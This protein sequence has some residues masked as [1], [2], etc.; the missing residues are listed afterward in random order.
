MLFSLWWSKLF[1]PAVL[2][3]LIKRPL[4]IPNARHERLDDGALFEHDE[5]RLN[6]N[7]ILLKPPRG[8]RSLL[9]KI[10]FHATVSP[11]AGAML[12]PEEIGALVHLGRQLDRQRKFALALALISCALL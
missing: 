8:A 10:L 7:I 9:H 11:G 1:E 5:R 4:S 6:S 12:F 2:D 3:S